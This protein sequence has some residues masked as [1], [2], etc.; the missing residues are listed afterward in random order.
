MDNGEVI[1]ALNEDWN[2]AGANLPEW[3][4]GFVVF[5]LAS[6]CFD[7]V[8]RSMPLLLVLWVTTTFLLAAARKSFPDEERG[9]RNAVTTALGF[10][11]MGL[12]AP[13][14]FRP[15]WS[16]A[17]AKVLADN[18]HYDTLRLDEAIHRG[19]IAEEATP[20]FTPRVL[21]Q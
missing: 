19:Q 2:F 6:E 7:K 12:P 17:P 14:K 20:T 16:G 5:L 9:L 21:R 15:A 13:S 10:V 18:S 1:L 3:M 8:S 11:P 4:S